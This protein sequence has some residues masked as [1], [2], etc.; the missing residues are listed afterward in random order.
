MTV[1]QRRRAFPITS[2]GIGVLLGLWMVGC[3][4]TVP[5]DFPNRLIG[6]DGQQF[7][8]EDLTQIANDLDLDEAGKRQA[9]RDLGIEDEELIDALLG[10]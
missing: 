1:K 2:A 9:L 5:S 7:E 3:G 8:V 10:L 6:A 4:T